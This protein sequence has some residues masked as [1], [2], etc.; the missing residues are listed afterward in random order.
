[1]H[2][3]I[4]FAYFQSQLKYVIL[5]WGG[6]KRMQKILHIQKRVLMLI[7]KKNKKE[8]CRQKFNP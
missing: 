3:N 8:S 1:V 4:Y 6:D 2:W 5:L 7:T